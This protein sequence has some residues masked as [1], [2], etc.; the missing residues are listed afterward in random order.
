MNETDLNMQTEREQSYLVGFWFRILKSETEPAKLFKNY[1][2]IYKHIYT[3]MQTYIHIY[4][5]IHIYINTYIYSYI[6]A[7]I[8]AYIIDN[9]QV[10]V[11]I[12][13]NF[14]T[15]YINAYIYT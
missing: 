5:N 9:Q 6:N 1:I 11:P 3:Y 13:F 10:F 2:C 12:Q 14:F 4:A 7:Y 15:W 8:Y